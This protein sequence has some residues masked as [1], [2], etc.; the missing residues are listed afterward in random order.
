MKLTILSATKLTVNLR[1]LMNFSDSS[2]PYLNDG[3]HRILIT[4]ALG[5]KWSN[6]HE[7]QCLFL[8]KH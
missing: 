3:N 1:E 6:L 8:N 2:L 5:I 7:R 4:V